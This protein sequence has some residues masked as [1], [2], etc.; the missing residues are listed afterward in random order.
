MAASG[1]EWWVLTESG[2]ISAE[3]WRR[4]V[5]LYKSELNHEEI[6]R[7]YKQAI[8]NTALVSK[9]GCPAAARGGCFCTGACRRSPD[10]RDL[11]E[12]MT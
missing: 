8:D 1:E 11:D 9:P 4:M 6:G 10:Q 5:E 7:V 2:L 12:G 3:D